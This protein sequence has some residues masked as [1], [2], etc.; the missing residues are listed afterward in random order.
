[1]R[2]AV[3]AAPVLAAIPS[4]LAIVALLVD[5]A[6]LA[7]GHAID[8]GPLLRRHPAVRLGA[9]LGLV[10]AALTLLEPRGLAAGD[11]AAADALLDAVLLVVLALIDIVHRLRVGS[12]ARGQQAARRQHGVRDEAKFG[13]SLSSGRVSTDQPS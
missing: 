5:L 7:I 4:L 3:G 13:H 9:T 8:A 6:A 2:T 1:M 12:P 11:L 10:D